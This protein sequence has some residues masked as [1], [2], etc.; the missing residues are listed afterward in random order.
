M[1]SFV[2]IIVLRRRL[3]VKHGNGVSDGVAISC[4]L[5]YWF[6]CYVRSGIVIIGVRS[7]IVIIWYQKWDCRQCASETG[8]LWRDIVMSPVQWCQMLYWNDIAFLKWIIWE[9]PVLVSDMPVFD[10]PLQVLTNYGYT[11]LSLVCG[12]IIGAIIIVLLLFILYQCEC[13]TLG[14]TTYT[15][16]ESVSKREYVYYNPHVY[17]HVNL[18]FRGTGP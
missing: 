9:F 1:L 13:Y 10:C 8:L 15:N 5:K 6:Y 4:L 3:P 2:A 17:E 18:A 14:S 16:T 7:G 11:V 12:V